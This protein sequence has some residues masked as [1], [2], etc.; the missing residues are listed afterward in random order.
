MFRRSDGTVLSELKE[1]QFRL[2]PELRF[3]NGVD[4]E[5]AAVL[6]GA[7]AG[8]DPSGRGQT[9]HPPTATLVCVARRSS[10][11]SASMI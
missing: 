2:Q 10:V 8:R 3:Q 11:R 4:T 9:R 6:V 5:S 7:E 1:S